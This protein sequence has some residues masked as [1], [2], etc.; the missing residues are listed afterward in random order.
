MP[1]ESECQTDIK[2]IYLKI[3]TVP[4]N[5]PGAGTEAQTEIDKWRWE[6]LEVAWQ[7]YNELKKK[8]RHIVEADA[9]SMS[10]DDS[11][12]SEAWGVEKK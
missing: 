6:M 12:L 3:R 8:V 11:N 1:T 2:N 4:K 5:V 7:K 10:S 9:Q